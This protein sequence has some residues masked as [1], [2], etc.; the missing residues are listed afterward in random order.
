MKKL[1]IVFAISVLC[2]SVQSFATLT[3]NV[4]P[5]PFMNL[6]TETKTFS[7][8]FITW[9]IVDS[10]AEIKGNIVVTVQDQDLPP[11]NGAVLGNLYGMPV[12]TAYIGN[13]AVKT[14]LD[15]NYS[16]EVPPMGLGQDSDAF[17]WESYTGSG[18]NKISV[19]VVFTLSPGDTATVLGRFDV[20]P[21]PEPA[22]MALL[23]FG[24]LLL[25]KRI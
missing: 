20:N 17:G 5:Q 16:L 14:L 21:V 12:Y 24:G 1:L 8:T 25:R 7:Q 6:T 13:D 2:L 22:T 15:D 11:G 23:A 18:G 3:V 4:D 9:G 19:E 10:L